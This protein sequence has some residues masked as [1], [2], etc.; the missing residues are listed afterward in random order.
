MLRLI[1]TFVG[2]IIVCVI[3]IYSINILCVSLPFFNKKTTTLDNFEQRLDYAKLTMSAA[4]QT[5][6]GKTAS[7]ALIN[8][9]EA[10]AAIQHIYNEEIIKA[11]V[12]KYVKSVVSRIPCRASVQ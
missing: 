1:T 6:C 2:M 4:I 3:G 11:E 10:M 8:T 12:V 9:P 7:E 5:K